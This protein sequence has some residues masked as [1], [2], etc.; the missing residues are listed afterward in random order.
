MARIVV[1]AGII[2]GD[3]PPVHIAS[4]VVIAP[5]SLPE[6][7]PVR[8]V[9]MRDEND[10]YALASETAGKTRPSVYGAAPSL[11]TPS[12][13]PRPRLGSLSKIAA[14]ARAPIVDPS[15]PATM[16]IPL[17]D[18]M[19][20]SDPT[21]DV[22]GSDV[23]RL[24]DPITAAPKRETASLG[25]TYL[26][27]AP[28]IGGGGVATDGLPNANRTTD[29]ALA[30]VNP[31]GGFVRSV[32]LDRIG[33][34]EDGSVVL[35]GRGKPGNV[36]QVYTTAGVV[37]RAVVNPEG[38]W[39]GTVASEAV[40]EVR[41]LRVDEMAPSGAVQ[42][43]IEAPFVYAREAPKVLRERRV[44]IQRGDTLWGIA[45]QYYGAGIRFAMIYGANTE[46]IRDPDLIYPGQVFLIPELV[47][48][49]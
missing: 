48:A 41:A 37:I 22:R 6:N 19:L 17:E 38:Q 47:D 34:D 24:A 33:Y 9:P 31:S 11:A 28:V 18:V 35:S 14:L 25:K 10:G 40:T 30:I 49:E 39:T 1:P 2:V 7:G 4:V 36:V 32:V 5:V 20:R 8:P 3:T 43:Q 16:S 27:K 46:L 42:S 12:V 44:V 29:R 23:S 21:T 45:R 13:P 26:D 15:T